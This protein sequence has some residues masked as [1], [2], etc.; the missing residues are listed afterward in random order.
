M[1]LSEAL[2]QR[3]PDV[4]A[5]HRRQRAQRPQR[6][7]ARDDQPAAS[8]PPGPPSV[9]SARPAAPAARRPATRRLRCDRDGRPIQAADGGSGHRVKRIARDAGQQVHPAGRA[10]PE[11]RLAGIAARTRSGRRLPG[12]AEAAETTNT[13]RPGPARPSPAEA[14]RLTTAGPAGAAAIG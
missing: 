1:N 14:A 5:G 9:L 13:R 4:N 2:G 6:A 8:L 12:P 3:Q 7:H 10:P 11:V